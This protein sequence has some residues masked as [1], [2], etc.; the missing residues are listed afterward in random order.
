[1][2]NLHEWAKPAWSVSVKNERLS[3]FMTDSVSERMGRAASRSEALLSPLNRWLA[4][5]AVNKR[6]SPKRSRRSRQTL[7]FSVF[8]F[9]FFMISLQTLGRRNPKTFSESMNKNANP[10]QKLLFVAESCADFDVNSAAACCLAR[11]HGSCS[12]STEY[13]YVLISAARLRTGAGA[14]ALRSLARQFKNNTFF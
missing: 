7:Y 12:F 4:D 3:G 1:M 8:L 9:S 13:K 10:Y 6:T 14:D 11:R 2:C 5:I